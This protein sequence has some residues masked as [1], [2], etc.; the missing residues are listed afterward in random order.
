MKETC[1]VCKKRF[2]LSDLYEYWGHVACE[3]CFGEVEKNA[4]FERAEAIERS[5]H[6]TDRFRGLDLGDSSIG[7]ANRQ[8]LKADIEIAKRN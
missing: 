4:D 5:R 3:K 2:D 8:I 6:K 1:S 7:K